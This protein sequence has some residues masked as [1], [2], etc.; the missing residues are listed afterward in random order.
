MESKLGCVYCQQCKDFIYDPTL[1]NVRLLQGEW[2]ITRSTE[3][4]MKA[5]W[6]S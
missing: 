1:E 2:D 6:E 4:S 3:N 5:D